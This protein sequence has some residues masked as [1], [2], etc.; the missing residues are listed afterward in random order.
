MNSISHSHL[1]PVSEVLAD[2]LSEYPDYRVLRSL[3]LPY[4]SMPATG[5]PPEG[6]CIALLDVETTSL[7][8]AT[9][10]IIELA[11]KLVFVDDAGNLRGHFPIFSWQQDPG[12][13]LDETIVQLTGLTDADLV[14]KRI[15]DEAVSR[16]LGRA[17]LLCAH[18]A[19]F[20]LQWILQRWPDLWDKPWACSCTE[21]DWAGLGFEGRSQPFLLQQHKWFS[22]PHRAPDDV[23]A[24]FWLLQE[25]R[26]DPDSD[27]D[28]GAGASSGAERTHLQ[29]LLSA[30]E[31]ET[32]RV[33]AAGAP[34][35]RKDLLRARGYRWDAELLRK[36]WWR[37]MAFED[38]E[39]EQLWFNRNDL[40]APRL[41]SVTARER[42][43]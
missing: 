42:H 8:A 37:E 31:R 12:H 30:S 23:W 14:G 9:G 16:L 26:P 13:P 25:S 20:D 34:F 5:A 11:I 39:A 7:D 41:L 36:I 10:N 22:R 32:V 33:E 29:R 18:N 35:A 1:D 2:R 15:D 38:V 24:L 3:P 40:P 28:D 43:R 4:A 21:I 6:R 17:D 19:S 27:D